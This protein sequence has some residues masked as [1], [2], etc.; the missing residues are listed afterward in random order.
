MNLEVGA[1]RLGPRMRPI[2]RG[3]AWQILTLSSDRAGESTTRP[4]EVALETAEALLNEC[5]A[6]YI[7]SVGREWFTVAAGAC[8]TLGFLLLRFTVNRT[9]AL[10]TWEHKGTRAW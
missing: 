10:W 6:S 5:R 9:L 7:S 3:G 2:N 4:D 8:G 1:W